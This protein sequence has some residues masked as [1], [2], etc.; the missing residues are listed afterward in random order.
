MSAKY[1]DNCTKEINLFPSKRFI[2]TFLNHSFFFVA[3]NEKNK[4]IWFKLSQTHSFV[5]FESFFLK[6]QCWK[7]SPLGS[8][9]ANGR[10]N[11]ALAY[12]KIIYYLT[13]AIINKFFKFEKKW[14]KIIY[15]RYNCMQ[16]CL[17]PLCKRNWK[18]RIIVE[19]LE[20]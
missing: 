3:K 1:N 9:S 14:F 20:R 17:T 18:P 7:I 12:T 4:K 16:F 15:I 13:T 11:I 2:I 5:Y 6:Y 10:G 8:T 19:S